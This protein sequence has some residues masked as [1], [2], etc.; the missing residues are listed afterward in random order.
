M[1]KLYQTLD[2]ALEDIEFD[3]RQHITELLNGHEKFDYGQPRLD[4]MFSWLD[5][6]LIKKGLDREQRPLFLWVLCDLACNAYREGVQIPN[7]KS[8]GIECYVGE[9]GVLMGTKQKSN[10][11]T[12]E[13]AALLKRGREVPS[14]NSGGYGTANFV[15]QRGL[16]I[17]EQEKAIYV[18]KFY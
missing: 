11:F 8:C 4:A 13:Q 15:E 3:G 7:E 16:L 18:S 5:I 14:T 10:F 1:L 9:R 2:Q 12:P 17:S 6:H